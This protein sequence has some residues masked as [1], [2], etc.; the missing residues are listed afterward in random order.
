[1]RISHFIVVLYCIRVFTDEPN[2]KLKLKRNCSIKWIENY[3]VTFVFK[4]F[5]PAVVG[6]L[7]QLSESRNG[8]V[9]Q[10][11]MPYL[12]ATKAIRTAGFLVSLEVINP[13]LKFTKPAA[14][15]L[16]GIEKLF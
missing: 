7:D 15:K 5:Y 14:K 16:Q 2:N 11:A 3:D 10:R 1:M 6:S 8:E 9:L 4:E 13:T 12:K